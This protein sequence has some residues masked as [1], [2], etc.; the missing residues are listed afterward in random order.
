MTHYKK[1][2]FVI[3]AT[4]LLA[5]SL[6]VYASK[7]PQQLKTTL[8]SLDSEP[9]IP[10][11]YEHVFNFSV[12][13]SA[14]TQEAVHIAWVENMEHD[15]EDGFYGDEN[16]YYDLFYR[17]LPNG[18]TIPLSSDSTTS[19]R[20][21]YVEEDEDGGVCILWS[22]MNREDP[23]IAHFYF[24]HSLSD[25]LIV[26]PVIANLQNLY[27]AESRIPRFPCKGD[28]SQVAWISAG[29][30]SSGDVFVWDISNNSIANVS[31]GA[32]T[33]E[34]TRVDNED[35]TYLAWRNDEGVYVWD[36]QTKDIREIATNFGY[37][38]HLYSDADNA[39]HMFWDH[40]YTGGI[41]LVRDWYYWDFVSES[42][43]RLDSLC[44]HD[45]YSTIDGAKNVHA[46]WRNC[47]DNNLIYWSVSEN[48]TTTV[49]VTNE[50]F[51]SYRNQFLFIGNPVEGVH[52]LWHQDEEGLYHWDNNSLEITRMD[53][54]IIEDYTGNL[55]SIEWKFDADGQIYALWKFDDG[56]AYW[57]SLIPS[58]VYIS[59]ML[60]ID[61]GWFVDSNN[62]F[63][64]ATDQSGEFYGLYYWNS[65]DKVK[66]YLEPNEIDNA[67]PIKIRQDADGELYIFYNLQND[68][69]NYWNRSEGEKL[70]G[71][72]GEIEFAFTDSHELYVYWYDLIGKTN[73]AWNA[74]D[75]MVEP[76]VDDGNIYL[77]FIVK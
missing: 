5:Y 61:Y 57:S 51:T 9:S 16:F 14:T 73:A 31:N 62:V 13:D 11:G 22:E 33:G 12:I 20:L 48:L 47:D 70:M 25:K 42:N 43:Q 59:E 4:I 40:V 6:R 19:A 28:D 52:A 26:S 64:L 41:N 32:G 38:I 50:Y 44:G 8:L 77:P 35:A 65:Q 29:S 54:V 67:Y 7:A 68:T 15:F 45:F 49:A 56:M 74:D 66:E 39:I 1:V 63:H 58:A 60:A 3:F 69:A 75:V 24:W 46:I 71:D 34:L 17:Q 36:S 53:D 76:P 37:D 21:F 55:N 72:A 2:A 23:E 10:E 30:F 18:E 27:P